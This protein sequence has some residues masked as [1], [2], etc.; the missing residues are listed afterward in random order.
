MMLLMMGGCSS[1]SSQTGGTGQV[2]LLEPKGRVFTAAAL[3]GQTATLDIVG[4]RSGIPM[5]IKPDGSVS[6]TVSQVPVGTW[7]FR[8]TYRA[9]SGSTALVIAEASAFG[10][11]AANTTT[12]VRL[13][14]IT[15]LSFPAKS[16][17]AGDG[18]SCALL[19]D[20]TVSCW[21]A[22]DSG[23]LGNGTFLRS[24]TPEAVTGLTAP[25]AI[26]ARGSYS[27]ALLADGT[28]SC[29]G[30]ITRS[31][32]PVAIT[33]LTTATAIA[34][35]DGHS[36]ALLVDRT[37]SCWGANFS[38]Q[39]GNGTTASSSTPVAV[40]GLKTA[41]AIAAG[42]EHSCAVLAGGTVS[43]WGGL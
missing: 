34:A 5:T 38:G 20:R 14:T 33:G 23:Q 3:P 30:A 11:I 18:H 6:A 8:I 4:V 41:T 13:T 19:A 29:W 17:A 21:G 16:V 31:S 42:A 25:T 10:T 2:V 28:V 22:N 1:D 12:V 43:C 36:C 39:L 9:G 27:C 26:A 7:E 37:V 35:G 24:S 15:K 32:T 40:S